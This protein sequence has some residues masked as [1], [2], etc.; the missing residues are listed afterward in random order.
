MRAVSLISA[1]FLLFAC[2]PQA[3]APSPTLAPI[4]A[5]PRPTTP[6]STA[7]AATAPPART[8]SP[9]LPAAGPTVP[10]AGPT[11]TCPRLAGGAAGGGGPLAAV[12]IAHQPGFDRVVFDFGPG[13]LP[14]YTIEQATSFVGPSGQTVPVQGN[15]HVG[16]RFNGA[17]T[18]GSY[19]GPRS[20][21]PAT[22]LVREMK[23]VEDFEGV[24]VWG[25]GLERL[26]CP[27]LRILG[28]PV[29]LVL[30]FPTPP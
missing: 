28:G 21:Q 20:F 15:A 8:A 3:A 7:V 29:R 14:Q 30:D 5:A 2:L 4:S 18:M 26:V 10:G 17:G 25:I 6:A 13:P 16:V 19:P 23:V 24:L 9:G 27:Q 22:P 1:V 12:R 11:G